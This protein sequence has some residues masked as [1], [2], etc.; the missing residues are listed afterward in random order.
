MA[1]QKPRRS[2]AGIR[3]TVVEA[4][5][6]HGWAVP[7]YATVRAVVNGLDPALL[8]LAH[9]GGKAYADRF[10]LLHRREA[11][12]PNAICPQPRCRPR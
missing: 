4:A 3:R 8:V 9:Q 1:L 11:A 6:E 7:S 10:E 12:K 2:I 5:K